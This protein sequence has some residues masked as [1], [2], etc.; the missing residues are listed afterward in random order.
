[1]GL[2]YS[3]GSFAF[4]G[5]EEPGAYIFYMATAPGKIEVARDGILEEIKKLII[6]EVSEEELNR[7]KKDLIGTETIRLET[8]QALAFQCAL[9]ELYGLGHQNF[10]Q[11][12]SGINRITKEDIRILAAK[13]FDLG[14]Y[15]MVV[16]GPKEK[17]K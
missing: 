7:A 15:T 3:V 13:Y 1:M 8:N 12:A 11:Y 5:L 16:V 4:I 17:T 9:D 10:S 2:A 14:S 6:H